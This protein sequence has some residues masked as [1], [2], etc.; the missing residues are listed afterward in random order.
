MAQQFLAQHDH[1]RTD[2]H[3]RPLVIFLILMTGGVLFSFGVTTVLFEFYT[4]RAESKGN[5]ANALKVV[6]EEPTTAPLLQVVPG[7]DLRQ[8]RASEAERYNS[9]GWVDQRTNVVHIPVD[10]AIDLLLEKG[11][12]SRGQANAQAAQ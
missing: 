9:Y 1:E 4:Q 11:V 12:P 6:D 7:L 10:K 8:I 5:P 2:A 3:V